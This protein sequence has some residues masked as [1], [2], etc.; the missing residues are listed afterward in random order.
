VD[1]SN[2]ARF[3]RRGY[4]GRAARPGGVRVRAD[5]S[6][7]LQGVALVAG[8]WR[9]GAGARVHGAVRVEGAIDVPADIALPLLE[10]LFDPALASGHFPPADIA[11]PRTVWLEVD[12]DPSP[13]WS[14]RRPRFD[15]LTAERR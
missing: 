2:R 4:A 14:S 8:S 13:S 12:L 3:E 11:M 9:G 10:F 5:A 6:L 7:S 15:A 1:A